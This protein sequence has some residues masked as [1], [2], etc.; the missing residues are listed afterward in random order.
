MALREYGPAH[1]T[2]FRE[3]SELRVQGVLKI[4]SGCF[5]GGLRKMTGFGLSAPPIG[6]LVGHHEPACRKRF[7]AETAPARRVAGLTCR[8]SFGMI[9]HSVHSSLSGWIPCKSH[10]LS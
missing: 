6:R 3:T 4:A 1:R 8:S 7:S 9:G 5:A 2:L 10:T